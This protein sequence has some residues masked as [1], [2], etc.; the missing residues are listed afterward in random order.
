MLTSRQDDPV[1]TADHRARAAAESVRS[2]FGHRLFGL[3]FTHLGAV[4]HPREG[5]GSPWHY[6]WQAHYLDVL[7]DET[8]RE[9]GQGSSRAADRSALTA[10]RLLRGIRL[11]NGLRWTNSYYDDMAWLA[12]AVDR[13]AQV[14]DGGGRALASL[15]RAL[16]SAHTPDLGGGLYWNSSRDFKNTPATGPAAL[17]FARRGQPER[18]QE[19]V[20]WLGE[21]LRDGA[22]GL[23]LDGIRVNAGQE[24]VVPDVYTYNQGPVLGALLELGGTTNLADAANLVA[25]VDSQLA[26][27]GVLLTHGAGDGGLF[28]G[29]LT[30]YLALAALSPL[31][32]DSARRTAA[33]LVTATADDLWSGRS[34][35]PFEGRPGG[36]LDLLSFPT[37]TGESARS[38]G[39]QLSTQLQA[40]M[41]LEA[42]YRVTAGAT[43]PAAD[44]RG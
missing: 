24:T 25:A 7:V 26:S 17:F 2:R 28:T 14:R 33:T 38:D 3:P 20:D 5:A 29:I 43:C 41:I 9:A 1:H 32:P 6:W 40:W 19:L 10:R 23:Y 13:L 15:D 18:A 11:R 42:S 27:E 39:A 36:G 44:G 22:T 8:L 31:L 35:N 37:G 30:R 34:A 12:L 4:H 21:R 16:C